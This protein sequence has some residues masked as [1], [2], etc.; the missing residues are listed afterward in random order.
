MLL[1]K[2]IIFTIFAAGIGAV[3]IP[4]WI[5]NGS[6]RAPAHWGVVQYLSVLMGLLAVGIYARCVWDF[7]T[8]GRGTPAPIAAPQVLVMRGLYQH[9]RNPIY[10]GV[11]LLILGEAA[12]FEAW[13]LA[14]YALIAFGVFQ[15]FVVLYEEPTLRR[16]FGQSYERYCQTVPRWLPARKHET[17]VS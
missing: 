12:F 15:L 13:S 6:P 9:V 14:V 7:A 2:N 3:L 11:L 4:Y 8:V 10:L 5:L 17:G 1:L 16:K